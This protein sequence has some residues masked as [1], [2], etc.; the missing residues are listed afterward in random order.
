[1]P[2]ITP[3]IIKTDHIAVYGRIIGV[4]AMRYSIP[5]FQT[6]ELKATEM[7][8]RERADITNNGIVEGAEVTL[9][10]QEAGYLVTGGSLSETVDKREEV[11][12]MNE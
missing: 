2:M 11:I 4:R 9:D 3:Q 12:I 6:V 5:M 7:S 1:M 8:F 10:L